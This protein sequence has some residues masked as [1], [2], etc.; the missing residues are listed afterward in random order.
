MKDELVLKNVKLIYLALKK[1]NL[2]DR[3]EEFFDV[4]MIG[5]IKGAKSYDD[6]LSYHESTYLYKCIYNALLMEIRKT[7]S[8][9]HIP[10]NNIV[11]LTTEFHDNLTVEDIIADEINIEEDA[12]KNEAISTLYHEINQ[13]SY[14]ERMT[15]NL[16][17]GLNGYQIMRQKQIAEALNTSQAN[18]SR[19]KIRALKKL[20]EA[21]EMED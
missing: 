7:K 3:Q 9:R 11:S 19:I 20:R 15:I 14:K 4:G 16:S 2:Y 21:L 18:V 6:S 5:L 8:T 1:L 13:L 10:D 12:I 17:F